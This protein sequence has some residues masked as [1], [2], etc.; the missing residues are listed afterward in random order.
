MQITSTNTHLK[1]SSCWLDVRALGVLA[2]PEKLSYR[3]FGLCVLEDKKI[4]LLLRFSVYNPK[5]SFSPNFE[6]VSLF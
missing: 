6:A 1:G 2:C 4:E 5:A 3:E